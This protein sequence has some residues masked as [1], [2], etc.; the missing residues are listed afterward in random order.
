MKFLKIEFG[1]LS[2]Q[3]KTQLSNQKLKYNTVVI[4]DFQNMN[5]RILSLWMN[6]IMNDKQ[7]LSC[8]K[9]L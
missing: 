8:Q 6:R 7:R 2:G 9:K 1:V 5:D 3:I 4:R